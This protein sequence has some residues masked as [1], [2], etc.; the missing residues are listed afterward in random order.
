MV[1]NCRVKV[2]D[3]GMCRSSFALSIHQQLKM[4]K[5]EQHTLQVVTEFVNAVQQVNLEKLGVLLHPEITWDQPA[6]TGFPEQKNQAEKYSR[7]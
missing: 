7:W 5:M 6:A 4:I 1:S 2:N 3:K